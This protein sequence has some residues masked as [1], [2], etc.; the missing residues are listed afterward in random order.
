MTIYWG[1]FVGEAEI[2]NTCKTAPGV[3]IYE[4]KVTNIDGVVITFASIGKHDLLYQMK[5]A[6]LDYLEFSEIEVTK[7]RA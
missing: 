7:A 5:T 2:C 4:G 1:G 3:V 6:I